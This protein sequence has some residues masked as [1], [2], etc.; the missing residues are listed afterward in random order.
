MRKPATEEAPPSADSTTTDSYRQSVAD[1]PPAAIAEKPARKRPL[2]KPASDDVELSLGIDLAPG[3]FSQAS[4]DD[5]GPAVSAD[6]LT[7][8]LV[9]AYIGIGNKVY[10]RGEGPGLSWERGV[11]LQFVS[12]GKWRWE[13]ADANAP[14]ALK[15]YKNDEVE[16]TALGTLALQPGHQHEV[17][18]SFN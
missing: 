18:A 17:T 11:P 4:P 14:V 7:R 13:T 6:G 3:D 16:C 12:I 2:K 10:V 9:T 8:L 1:A 5:V 15:L